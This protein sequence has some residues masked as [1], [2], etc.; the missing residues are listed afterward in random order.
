MKRL[1]KTGALQRSISDSEGFQFSLRAPEIAETRDSVF[2]FHCLLPNVRFKKTESISIPL[3]LPCSRGIFHC[4]SGTTLEYQLQ[5]QVSSLATETWI[6]VSQ[7]SCLGH[8]APFQKCLPVLQDLS[9]EHF[10]SHFQQREAPSNNAAHLPC[11]CCGSFMHPKL[12]TVVVQKLGALFLSPC[13]VKNCC[14]EASCEALRTFAL[15]FEQ[16]SGSKLCVYCT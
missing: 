10:S 5:T 2:L 15:C 14:S 3:C 6:R 13:C 16:E 1:D 4:L 7:L 8:V 12:K 9:L 11:D